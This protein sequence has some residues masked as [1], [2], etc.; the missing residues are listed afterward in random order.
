MEGGWFDPP[1]LY[2][3]DNHYG[4]QVMSRNGDIIIY[5]L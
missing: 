2:Y 4:A 5:F 1:F 3:E